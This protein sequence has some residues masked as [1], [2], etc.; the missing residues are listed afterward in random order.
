MIKKEPECISKPEIA[1][2][3]A[4]TESKDSK[5]SGAGCPSPSMICMDL[6]SVDITGKYWPLFHA[7]SHFMLY[8]IFTVLT[9]N[10]VLLYYTASYCKKD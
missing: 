4:Q 2:R 9:Y 6:V 1:P 7:I 3:C 5:F 10:Y 8:V